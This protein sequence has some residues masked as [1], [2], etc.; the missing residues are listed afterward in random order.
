[1]WYFFGSPIRR[2]VMRIINN[3]IRNAE[4]AYKAEIKTMNQQKHAKLQAYLKEFQANL[5]TLR[6]EWDT[7]KKE[8]LDKRV[9]DILA[10]VI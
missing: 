3:R 9:G 6:A 5:K 4:I 8:L 1:M 2:E 7:R 10:K